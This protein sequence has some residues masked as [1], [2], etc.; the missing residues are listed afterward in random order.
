MELYDRLFSENTD[1]VLYSILMDEDEYSLY[2]EFQKE[3]ASVKLL[4]KQS[5]R[6]IDGVKKGDFN[7]T[8]RASA[9][10]ARNGGFRRPLIDKNR[11][12]FDKVEKAVMKY[13]DKK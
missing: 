2:S 13:A 1:E 12:L 3:F 11:P 5:K 6:I 9:V 7:E 4:K 10:F 8:Q